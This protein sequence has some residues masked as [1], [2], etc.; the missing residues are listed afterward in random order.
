MAD[1]FTIEATDDT[2]DGCPVLTKLRTATTQKGTTPALS[3]EMRDASGLPLDLSEI[4]D[5]SEESEDDDDHCGQVI[6]RFADAVDPG[7]IQQIIGE[8]ED[9]E[10]G[11]VKVSLTC[12]ITD[13]A[14]IWRF[15]VAVT[16]VEGKVTSMNDGLLS[17]ERGLFGN[18]ECLTG[19]PTLQELRIE[20]RDS[21]IENV[22]DQ[23]LEFSD[24]ELVYCLTRPLLQWNERPPMIGRMTASRFPYRYNWTRAAI[25]ELLAIAAH[26]YR[27][28]KTQM[29]AA[30]ITDQSLDRDIPYDSM[31]QVLRQEWL[32]FVD[33]KKVEINAKAAWGT[34]P[35]G[36]Y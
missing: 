36:W 29:T 9:A 8:V 21:G 18:T 35:S 3:W 2:A 12:A 24:S 32:A 16:N 25:G 22:R 15:Q 14:G 4:C 11:R 10:T 33:H 30:G 19:P 28:N 31:S 6:F 27:R 1:P 13:R 23:A 34:L 17:V 7:V 26:N 20:L 5:G